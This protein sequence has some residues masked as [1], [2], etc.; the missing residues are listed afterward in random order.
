MCDYAISSKETEGSSGHMFDGDQ[1]FN[2]TE[3]VIWDAAMSALGVRNDVMYK[4]GLVP[5]TQ[6]PFFLA[7]LHLSLKSSSSLCF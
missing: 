1:H 3:M 5:L 4:L 2:T 6:Y 7:T